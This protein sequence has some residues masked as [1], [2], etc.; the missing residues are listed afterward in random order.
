M[1]PLLGLLLQQ[2]CLL[3]LPTCYH[4]MPCLLFLWVMCDMPHEGGEMALNGGRMDGDGGGSWLGNE[5]GLNCECGGLGEEGRRRGRVVSD[6]C[7]ELNGGREGRVCYHA[8]MYWGGDWCRA[9]EHRRHCW[10][11]KCR[12]IISFNARQKRRNGDRGGR[13][14]LGA[15]RSG[16]FYG[17]RV[18]VLRRRGAS[19]RSWTV[20]KMRCS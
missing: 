10:N 4:C 11:N 8:R 19:C 12:C 16:C 2:H 1:L 13:V 7:G 18:G 9:T 15:I 20:S 3:L 5:C 17:R 14:I 6:L